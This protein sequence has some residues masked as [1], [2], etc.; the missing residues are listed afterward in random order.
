M[1]WSDSIRASDN[2]HIQGAFH[3]Q[4]KRVTRVTRDV[5]SRNDALKVTVKIFIMFL[6][7]TALLN[8]FYQKNLISFS[9]K[10]LSS[11]TVL[12][13]IIIKKCFLS[14]ILNCNNIPQYY[15]FKC[16]LSNKC[17]L[18]KNRTPPKLLNI[19]LYYLQK[20]I[21]NLTHPKLL[22]IIILQ[23]VIWID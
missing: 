5:L 14:S 8:C 1:N 2:R 13:L 19:I 7:I 9:Q 17:S 23:N 18:K 11:T 4:R 3:I 21:K 15:S 6:K 12:K 16:I 20:K 22:H 10:I